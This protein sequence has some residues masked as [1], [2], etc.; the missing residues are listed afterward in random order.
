MKEWMRTLLSGVSPGGDD[1]PVEGTDMRF[2]MCANFCANILISDGYAQGCVEKDS[3]KKQKLGNAI[4]QER[5]FAAWNNEMTACVIG[6]KTHLSWQMPNESTLA[7]PSSDSVEALSG[8]MGGVHMYN[9]AM[10][11]KKFFYGDINAVAHSTDAGGL[12]FAF[13][14]GMAAQ[15]K[16]KNH[17]YYHTLFTTTDDA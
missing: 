1:T 2:F 5:C 7:A 4:D 12:G 14:A 9:H 15:A 16:G 3:G 17:K 10:F 11:N 6:D 13:I 8:C